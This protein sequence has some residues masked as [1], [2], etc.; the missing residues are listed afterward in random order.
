GWGGAAWH[1]AFQAVSAFCNAG[2]STFSDSLAAFR[3]APLTLVVMAAL[4][5]LGGLGF[6]VLEELK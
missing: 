2:F 3:G 5:I 6:I 1:A 4:I